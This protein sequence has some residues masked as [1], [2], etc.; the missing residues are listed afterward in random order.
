MRTV[1]AVLM[2][3]GAGAVMTRIFKAV[4]RARK[5]VQKIRADLQARRQA[6]ADFGPAR[7]DLYQD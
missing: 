4:P 3:V 6:M 5:R 7:A 2:V 1:P